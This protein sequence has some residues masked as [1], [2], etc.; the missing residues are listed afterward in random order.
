MRVAIDPNFRSSIEEQGSGSIIGVRFTYSKAYC[1]I[2]EIG[3]TRLLFPGVFFR[4]ESSGSII[5]SSSSQNES[6]GG[7]TGTGLRRFTSYYSHGKTRCSFAGVTFTVADG[8][9]N[10]DGQSYSLID[11][12]KE[13]IFVNSK[14]RVIEVVPI[15][16]N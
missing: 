1:G 11:G 4:G 8:N 5:L 10:L 7:V 6:V 16:I 12:S 9:L 2:V 14:G 15:E 13:A 3:D